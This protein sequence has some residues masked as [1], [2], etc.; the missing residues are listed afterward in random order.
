MQFENR[1]YLIKYDS[2]N[3]KWNTVYFAAPETA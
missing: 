1:R 2:L 3:P